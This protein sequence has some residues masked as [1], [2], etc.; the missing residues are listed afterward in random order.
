[1]VLGSWQKDKKLKA[2]EH[3]MSEIIRACL[4]KYVNMI[5]E[6]SQ[7]SQIFKPISVSSTLKRNRV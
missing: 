5:D 3:I 7:D 6:M 1:M 4:V 2:I